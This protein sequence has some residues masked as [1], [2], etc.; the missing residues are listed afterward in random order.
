MRFHRAFESF[1]EE[2]KFIKNVSKTT[3]AN[4]HFAWVALSPHLHPETPLVDFNKTMLKTAV[5]KLAASGISAVSTNTYLKTLNTFLS[6][7]HEEGLIKEPLRMPTLIT[8]VKLPPV[9]TQEHLATVLAFKPQTFSARRTHTMAILILDSGLRLSECLTLRRVD[10]DMDQSTL[11]LFGKGRKERVVP[12]SSRMLGLLLRWL[13]RHES[14]FVFPKKTGDC[15]KSRMAIQ[16]FTELQERT[17][18]AGVRFS[19]HTLRHSMAS[20]YIRNGGDVFRLQKILGHSSLEMTKRY[21]TLNVDDPRS[22]H[23]RLSVIATGPHRK[24]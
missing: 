11:Q 13:R 17:G 12:I 23:D 22:V 14:E 10:L 8:E 15:M 9:L 5:V 18:I 21:V 2:R 1:V 24:R 7:A 19:A 16:N 3:L 20:G 4:Y 6:W